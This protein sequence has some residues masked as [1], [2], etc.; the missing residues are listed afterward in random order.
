M[1]VED[2]DKD[3]WGKQAQAA[4]VD[5][6]SIWSA[7]RPAKAWTPMKE[8]WLLLISRTLRAFSLEK[9]PSLMAATSLWDRSL[10]QQHCSVL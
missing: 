6:Y 7:V 4:G 8:M 2:L 1:S 5:T 10:K 3:G 9:V